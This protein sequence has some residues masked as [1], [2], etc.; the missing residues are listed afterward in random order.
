MEPGSTD[1]HSPEPAESPE[2]PE[3]PEP[4]EPA[5]SPESPEPVEPAVPAV[6]VDRRRFLAGA[7]AGGAAATVA[8]YALGRSA[9]QEAPPKPAAGPVTY[10]V[11]G[12][13]Q[14]GVTTPQPAAGL[15]AAFEVEARS[16]AGLGDVLG[17]LSARAQDLMTGKPPPRRDGTVPPP[18]SGVLGPAPAPEG[19]T[20]TVSV[21][22]SLFD[23][24]FGLAALRPRRLTRMPAFPNDDLD[25]A[26]CHGDLLVQVCADQRDTVLHALR[27]LRAATAQMLTQRWMLEG[28]QRP[29][30]LPAGQTSV[31]NLLGF[32]DG[33][34]NPDP[35]D[36]ALM[37]R[38][39]WVQPGGPE[40]AWAAGGTYQVVRIIR[41]FVEKWDLTPLQV[42]E[43]II[44]RHRDS[45]AP[46]GRRRE[47]EVPD[48]AGDPQGQVTPPFAHIRLANPRTPA[49]GAN[50]ILRRGFNYAR[51]TD[52]PD[53][54]DTGLLFIAYQ[55]DL[56][57]GFVAVQQRL[58]GERLEQFIQPVGGGFFFTLPGATAPDG[59][60]GDTLL[61]AAGS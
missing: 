2:P 59:H 32:K 26:R 21:G 11:F 3:S 47:D 27:E 48:F 51:D 38:L 4:A 8:G 55:Q 20:I 24:R 36:Q 23:K 28:F 33:T 22:A 13:H 44:G 10:S 15:V 60:L 46:L 18:D 12:L 56:Q 25:P 49:T 1:T 6:Q 41:N 53:Q 50:R 42:Q 34:T 16:R 61:A 43:E 7:L 45:G 29:N 35:R 39:V 5:E 31:R 54:F 37:D 52:G 30:T 9:G 17:V 40:P 19:L 57:R 14:P 58:N